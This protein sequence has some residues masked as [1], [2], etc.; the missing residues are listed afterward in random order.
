MKFISDVFRSTNHYSRL[1]WIQTAGLESWILK[2]EP[3]RKLEKR[4]SMVIAG[5]DDDGAPGTPPPLDL[6]HTHRGW[7]TVPLSDFCDD[8][9]R[10]KPSPALLRPGISPTSAPG[11]M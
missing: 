10:R 9:E 2:A 5:A 11:R 1:Y 7:P 8:P 3:G 4:R 6:D